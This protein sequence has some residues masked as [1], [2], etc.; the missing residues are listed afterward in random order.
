MS[1]LALSYDVDTP[2]P[3]QHVDDADHED[4]A[5][6]LAK[7]QERE[8]RHQE[9][10]K[11]ASCELNHRLADM[12]DLMADGFSQR[13]CLEVVADLLICAQHIVDGALAPL[14]RIQSRVGHLEKFMFRRALPNTEKTGLTSGSHPD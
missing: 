11:L 12:V 10:I 7:H 6:K 3:F 8:A 5:V 14:G 4:D 1:A 9:A 13:N 2:L